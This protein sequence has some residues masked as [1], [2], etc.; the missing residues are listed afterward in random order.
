MG[1]GPVRHV[2]LGQ[3]RRAC[4]EA[5]ALKRQGID[6]LEARREKKLGRQSP[7]PRR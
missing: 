2:G 4:Y 1:L 3:A 7:K 5:R 6:T